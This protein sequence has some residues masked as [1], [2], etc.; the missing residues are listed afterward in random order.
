MSK[1]QNENETVGE[2]GLTDSERQ[3]ITTPMSEMAPEGVKFGLA[4]LEKRAQHNW[5]ENEEYRR[6]KE[7]TRE[8]LA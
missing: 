7:A 8:Q 5:K 4:I 3:Y 2:D 6:N 1:I